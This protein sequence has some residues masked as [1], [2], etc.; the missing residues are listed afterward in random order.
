MTRFAPAGYRS[1]RAAA[2]TPRE[3]DQGVS[4]TAGVGDWDAGSG[5]AVRAW[6]WF[7]HCHDQYH[8]VGGMALEMKYA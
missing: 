1:S 2:T 6:T 4:L 7:L 5:K 3:V 8:H